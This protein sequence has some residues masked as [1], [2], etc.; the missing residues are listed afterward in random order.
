M[1]QT[2]PL[3]TVTAANHA[4]LLAQEKP[5]LLDFWAPWC[6]PCRQLEPTI[7]ALATANAGRALVAKVNVDEQAELASQ[8]GVRSIP[9]IFVLHKGEVKASFVGLKSQAELQQA[10][11]AL[12]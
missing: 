9:S 4:A 3:L 11:D 1:S 5:L 10:L 7:A 12:L 6:G 2:N 8:Y